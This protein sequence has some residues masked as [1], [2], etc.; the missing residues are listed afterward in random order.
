[1]DTFYTR[2]YFY[3]TAGATLKT[4]T[5]KLKFPNTKLTPNMLTYAIPTCKNTNGQFKDQRHTP[6]QQQH[7]QFHGPFSRRLSQHQQVLPKSSTNPRKATN[8]GGFHHN[9]EFTIGIYVLVRQHVGDV[10][11]LTVQ[12]RFSDQYGLRSIF[13][14]G[15]G[16]P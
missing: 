10:A 11:F 5:L 7:Q 8:S 14:G 15:H 12:H 6:G 13:L 16:W 4:H 1:M 9:F 3:E 2:I